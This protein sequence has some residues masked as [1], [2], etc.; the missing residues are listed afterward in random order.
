MIAEDFTDDKEAFTKAAIKGR[1]I[2][3]PSFKVKADTVF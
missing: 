2:N 3:L 1:E